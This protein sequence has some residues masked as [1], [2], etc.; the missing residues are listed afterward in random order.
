MS[1]SN[2]N[3][4]GEG[5]GWVQWRGV[6]RVRPEGSSRTHLAFRPEGLRPDR[7]SGQAHNGGSCKR[8]SEVAAATQLCPCDQH[9]GCA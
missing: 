5:T 1:I 3:R 8:A 2:V 9:S 7:N 6:G 4:L